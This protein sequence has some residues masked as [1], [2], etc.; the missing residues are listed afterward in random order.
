MSYLSLYLQCLAQVLAFLVL[1]LGKFLLK[2]GM[3]DAILMLKAQP[4][5]TS[6]KS[7]LGDRVLGEAE[8]NSFIA[9]PGK[10][11]HS[12]LLPPKTVPTPEDLMRSFTAIVQGWGVFRAC[13]PL[14]LSQVILMSVFGSFSLASDGFLQYEEC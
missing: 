4:L 11:G 6:A 12:G 3:N 14:I 10:E 1:V 8:T 9:L 2:Q 7:N 5:C 13:I